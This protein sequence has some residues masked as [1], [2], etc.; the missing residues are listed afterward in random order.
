MIKANL[1]TSEFDKAVRKLWEVGTVDLDKLLKQSAGLVIRD[2]VRYTPPFGNAPITEGFA[3]KK[4]VG[5]RA[6]ELGIRKIYSQL[7]DID[8]NDERREK[9]VK[10]LSRTNPEKCAVYL[11]MCGYNVHKVIPDMDTSYHKKSRD[12]KG[13]V[14]W[15]KSKGKVY[16]VKNG[17]VKKYIKLQQKKVGQAMSGWKRAVKMTKAKGIGKWAL[18]SFPRGKGRA[19]A[20][21]K[22]WNFQFEATNST[23]YVSGFK[24]LNITKKA[25]RNQ[26]RNLVKRIDATI[27]YVAKKSGF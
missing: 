14:R 23:P 21:G 7:N 13:H 11:R 6:V 5:F 16:V 25:M 24:S 18:A 9:E 26:T 3:T 15:S 1:N 10:K 8:W 12:S 27:K 20:Q 19:R 4:R 17:V 22:G 2:S